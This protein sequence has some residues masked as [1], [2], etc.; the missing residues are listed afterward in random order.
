[1]IV[2]ANVRAPLAEVAE[3]ITHYVARGGGLLIAAGDHVDAFAYRGSMGSLL[4]AVVRS[5]APSSPPLAVKKPTDV[6]SV[7]LPDL[8][9]GL[10]TGGT[11]KRLL[12]E[13]AGAPSQTLLSFSDGGALLVAGPHGQGT[14]ALWT[15][16]LDDDWSDLPLTPGFLPLLTGL[17]RGLAAVDALP[18]GPHLAGSVL[19]TRVPVGVSALYLVTPD[20]RRV[21]LDIGQRQRGAA[22]QAARSDAQVQIRDTAV[23]G[24]YRAFAVLDGQREQE[25]EQLS[26]VVVPDTRDSDLT[27]RAPKQRDAEHRATTSAAHARGFEGWLWLL[28]GVAAIAEGVLRILAKRREPQPG[29]PQAAL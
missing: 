18:P 5:N 16:T 26:F 2:L 13:P 15:T 23:T 28:F 12:L 11:S 27:L 19:S 17:V 4:P 3:R 29:T 8:G 24:V 25:L 7:L 9:R 22:N 6:D 14:V 10:E 1:V 21:D 20:G